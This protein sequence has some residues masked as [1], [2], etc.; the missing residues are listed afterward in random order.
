MTR[1]EIASYLKRNYKGEN[2]IPPKGRSTGAQTGGS[3][4]AKNGEKVRYLLSSCLIAP[5]RG[6]TLTVV[7]Y[8]ALKNEDMIQDPQKP[9]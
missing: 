6:T 2:L 8:P 3:L 1:E 5:S 4:T 7:R 9:R